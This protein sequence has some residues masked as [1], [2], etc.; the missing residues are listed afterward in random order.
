MLKAV[1][2]PRQG[3]S[4]RSVPRA[5]AAAHERAHGAPATPPAAGWP[6][7]RENKASETE[8]RRRRQPHASAPL[9]RHDSRT[10]L[11]ALMPKAPR[12]RPRFSRHSGRVDLA[13][14]R[15][16]ARKEKTEG[17]KRRAPLRCSTKP[18]PFALHPA[19]ASS[20][21]HA[22]AHSVHGRA[23]WLGG[24]GSR[25]LV[26][27]LFRGRAR[28]S[29]EV[30][31]ASEGKKRR[32]RWNPGRTAAEP[33]Q[34]CGRDRC[35]GRMRWKSGRLAAEKRQNGSVVPSDRS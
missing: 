2:V 23:P 33:R 29:S 21:A 7:K 8:H 9:H 14:L 34:N 35:I 3:D 28:R 17:K 15:S 10:K 5:T 25:T 32:V 30:K 24:G 18:A 26:F 13:G 16:R 11:A 31:K 22:L 1:L 20:V 12:V 19:W 27:F 6:L 4:G